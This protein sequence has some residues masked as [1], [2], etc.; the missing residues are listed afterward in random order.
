[1]TGYGLPTGAGA[2]FL[3]GATAAALGAGLALARAAPGRWMRA[4]GWALV[5]AVGSAGPRL[6]RD[7]GGGTRMLLLCG[8]LVLAMKVLV[9]AEARLDG[10]SV[11]AGAR[12]LA[13]A[14]LWP[15]MRPWAFAGTPAGGRPG[16]RGDVMRGLTR[17]G[18][19][20]LLLLLARG[21]GTHGG[22]IVPATVLA[23]VGLGLVA[24]F[25]LF[26][27]LAGLWRRQGVAVRP[28]FDEPL[29]SRSLEEFWS[30]RWNLAFSEMLQVAV[31]RPLLARLG[32]RA[33]TFASFLVSGLLHELAL[34][35]PARGGYGL[36]LA[37]FALHGGLVLLEP[38]LRW[39]PG[40][41]GDRRRRAWTLGWVLLPA[42]LVLHP[43]A[44]RA[45]VLPL[46]ESP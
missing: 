17:V 14:L 34:S 25:G 28:L 32:A 43:P 2:W 8:A 37:Y 11:P 42:V 30:R 9:T 38:F 6:T 4:L 41:A 33:A 24:H 22:R 21:L 31:R 26:R 16:W 18:A 19:G 3:V 35:V 39:G 20:V 44:L 46:L 27:L 15:G 1:V 12:W 36:P 45:I 40:T 7:E 29:R 10:R 5:L 13:F 23:L